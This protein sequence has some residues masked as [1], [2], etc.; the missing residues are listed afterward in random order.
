[1]H[2]WRSETV[3]KH[4]DLV[5]YHQSLK[6][7]GISVYSGNLLSAGGRGT[8]TLFNNGWYKYKTKK[9]KKQIKKTFSI[10]ASHFKV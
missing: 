10:D 2:K 7:K 5:K 1:M 8:I 4:Q 3:L 6:G 9:A